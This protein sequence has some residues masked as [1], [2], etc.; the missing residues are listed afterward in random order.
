MRFDRDKFVTDALSLV[1]RSVPWE[2]Q[3]RNPD[4]GIDCIGLPRWAYQLQR[5]LPDELEAEFAAYH[6]KPDGERML[7]IMR[8]WFEE[9]P[10][11]DQQ[12]L[13]LIVGHMPGDLVVMYFKRNP[14]HMGVLVS[15]TEVVEA[16]KQGDFASVR[17]GEPRLAIAA[18]FRIP[19]FN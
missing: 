1:G 3:G 6:R 2:H 16:F 19:E 7:T 17:K 11:H 12:R 10:A 9:V 5:P 15:A 18:V 8:R 4:V 13:P 14:C